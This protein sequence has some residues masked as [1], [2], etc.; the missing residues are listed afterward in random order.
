[1]DIT[2]IEISEDLYVQEKSKKTQIVL[3]HNDQVITHFIIDRNGVIS[4]L[5]NTK[6]W[7]YHLGLENKHF[8]KARIQPKNLDKSSISIKLES[9]GPVKM[10]ADGNFYPKTLEENTPK[11]PVR[12]YY[13]YCTSA[14]WRG[15]CYYE[16]YTPKQIERLQELLE[17][18]CKKHNISVN[19]NDNMWVVATRA[20]KGEKGVFSHTS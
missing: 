13:E 17:N 1:M 15:N 16:M 19:Y 7:S 18:L 11:E 5:F 9:C 3:H 8:S 6:Y 2:Q 14:P 12:N 10:H 20:L 4:Q